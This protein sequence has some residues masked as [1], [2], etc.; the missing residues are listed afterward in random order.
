MGIGGCA[1]ALPP[2]GRRVEGLDDALENSVTG[3]GQL[4]QCGDGLARMCRRLDGL[5]QVAEPVAEAEPVIA[6]G[7]PAGVEQVGVARDV[8]ALGLQHVEGPGHH[9]S[10]LDRVGHGGGQPVE[11]LAEQHDGDEARTMENRV[12]TALL[13]RSPRFRSGRQAELIQA[14]VDGS[15]QAGDAAAMPGVRAVGLRVVDHLVERGA[16]GM[17]ARHQPALR[18]PGRAVGG[19]FLGRRDD[20]GAAVGEFG[21]DDVVTDAELDGAGQAAPP[22]RRGQVAVR[23]VMLRRASG[24]FLDDGFAGARCDAG[25]LALEGDQC[26]IGAHVG[27]SVAGRPQRSTT[28]GSRS[29]AGTVGVV[30]F[31]EDPAIGRFGLAGNRC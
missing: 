6:R 7:R 24:G 10:L 17:P 21:V 15:E 13:G 3:S 8:E 2:V 14:R 19:R 16:I 29:R 26:L 11:A 12:G 5:G 30:A 20:Q 18:I 28:A 4:A 27:F 23:V 1:Q 22:K 25:A 9:V 31:V